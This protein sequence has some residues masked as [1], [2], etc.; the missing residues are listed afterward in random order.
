[1]PL[2]G[3]IMR[4]R[5]E[6]DSGALGTLMCDVKQV[7]AAC[8]IGISTVWNLVAVD[9]TFPKPIYLSPRVARWPNEEIVAWVKA[10]AAARNETAKAA[11]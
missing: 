8:N 1:M 11:A 4:K 10:R 3:E 9:P 6:R 5:L 2:Q 7:A